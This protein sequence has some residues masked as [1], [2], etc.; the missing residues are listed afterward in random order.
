MRIV[1]F[2]GSIIG[3]HE[4]FK[5]SSTLKTVELPKSLTTIEYNSFMGCNSLIGITIPNSVTTIGQNAFQSC[6]SLTNIIIPNSVTSIGGLAFNGCKNLKI[7]TVL[8]TTPPELGN[9]VFYQDFQSILPD[10]MIYVPSGSV[11]YYKNATNWADYASRIQAI[12]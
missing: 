5:N 1:K 10:F 11:N 6:T 12:P 3:I 9:Y 4:L 7:I 8:S 2:S